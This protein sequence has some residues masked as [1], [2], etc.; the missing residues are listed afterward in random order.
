MCIIKAKKNS[1]GPPG[2]AGEKHDDAASPDHA[3]TKRGGGAGKGPKLT[4]VDQLK[5]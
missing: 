3:M 4:D 2:L 1:L 5:W